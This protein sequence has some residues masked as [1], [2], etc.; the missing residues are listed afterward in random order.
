[1]NQTN[2]VTMI[3][4]FALAIYAGLYTGSVMV[5]SSGALVL[6]TIS[7]MC[8]YVFQVLDALDFDPKLTAAQIGL[9]AAA[10]ICAVGSL[11]LIA[12]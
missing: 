4:A 10:V 1:M 9:W 3:T 12:F 11:A 8:A 2:S 7:A 6:A 5:D